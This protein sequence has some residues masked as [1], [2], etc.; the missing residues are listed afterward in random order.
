M[1]MVKNPET[2]QPEIIIRFTNFETEAQAME[3]AHTFKS[4][5]EY[6]ELNEKV[7]LH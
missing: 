4:Q 7:T 6:E 5:P 2:K 3:F 1:F